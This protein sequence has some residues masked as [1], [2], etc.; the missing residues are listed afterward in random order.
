MRKILFI[1]ISLIFIHPS[2]ALSEGWK[3]NLVDL[4]NQTLELI[5][6]KVKDSCCEYGSY[7]VVG[8]DSKPYQ[9]I[10]EDGKTLYMSNVY[11]PSDGWDHGGL[12]SW[13]I[14][15]K[16]GYAVNLVVDD[17]LFFEESSSGFRSLKKQPANE[18]FS[19]G[20]CKYLNR[21]EVKAEELKVK[22]ELKKAEQ[23]EENE[24][25]EFEK[26][27]DE[28]EKQ[29]PYKVLLKCGQQGKHLGIHICFV[30]TDLTI[31]DGET[32]KKYRANNM[33]RAGNETRQG[34]LIENVSKD[35]SIAA[36]NASPDLILTLEV[37]KNDKMVYSR[38]ANQY[39]VLNFR[40]N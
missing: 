7:V 38:N 19:A 29:Y 22:K 37:Y 2:K 1:L 23:E 35:F 40:G 8:E 39:G 11:S 32:V 10:Y 24:Q 18:A 6:K 3:C 21:K 13:A 34:L 27:Q 20:T 26:K 17:Y 36:Q 30:D 31:F 5:L 9:I 28:Y 4:N 25:K 12:E 15:K 33:S 14:R 16:D